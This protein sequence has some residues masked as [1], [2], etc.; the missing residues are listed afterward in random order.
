ME[1][2]GCTC[3]WGIPGVTQL[4]LHSHVRTDRYEPGS[5]IERGPFAGQ[6]MQRVVWE[7]FEIR[8]WVHWKTLAREE[9]LTREGIQ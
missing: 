8:I 1:E 3:S 7:E 9:T 2:Y 4:P 6:R 5:V